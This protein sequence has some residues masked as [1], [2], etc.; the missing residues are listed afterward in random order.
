MSIY[1][2]SLMFV[3]L[4]YPSA[5][6]RALLSGC[7]IHQVLLLLKGNILKWFDCFETDKGVLRDFSS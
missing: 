6:I 3:Q 4:Q 5:I 2:V 7:K 1:T